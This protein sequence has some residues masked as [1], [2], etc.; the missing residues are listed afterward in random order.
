MKIVV[1]TFLLATTFCPLLVQAA[2]EKEL[3]LA[4]KSA[5]KELEATTDKAKGIAVGKLKSVLQ[6]ELKK[7]NL[8]GA[9]LIQAKI[10]ELSVNE[11]AVG[12][13]SY[14]DGSFVDLREDGSALHSHGAG[15]RWAIR[16][17]KLTISYHNGSID[18]VDLPPKN[19]VSQCINNRG[20]T[21]EVTKQ[22]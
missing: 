8:E 16:G 17:N 4:A 22:K 3:P 5:L 10:D 1:L 14:K 6:V 7:G 21:F 12:R 13:W 9:N 18:T 20:A 2:D 15:G 19:G 11:D